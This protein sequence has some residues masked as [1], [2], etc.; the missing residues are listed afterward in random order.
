MRYFSAQYK[1]RKSW[2]KRIEARRTKRKELKEGRKPDKKLT[3]IFLL[4]SLINHTNINDFA[5]FITEILNIFPDK[6]SPVGRSHRLIE[7]L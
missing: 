1:T 5:V 6:V 2:Q 4:T 7:N 3:N